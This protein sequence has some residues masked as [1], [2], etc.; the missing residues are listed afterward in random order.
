MPHQMGKRFIIAS[1]ITKMAVIYTAWRSIQIYPRYTPVRSWPADKPNAGL[2]ASLP[3][4]DFLAYERTAP[5]GGGQP[6]YPQV[7]LV[8]LAKSVSEKREGLW[9]PLREVQEL[10]GDSLHQTI[11]PEWSSNGILS[12]YDTNQQAFIVLDPRSGKNTSLP[13]QTGEPGS[14]D[15]SAKYYVA[16]EIFLQHHW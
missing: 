15:P 9:L 11:Q 10:A 2:R 13:N 12:F 14:W 4:E 16:P 1:K 8:K 7:W 5:A 6:G 3:S